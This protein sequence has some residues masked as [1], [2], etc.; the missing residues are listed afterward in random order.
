MYT[1]VALVGVFLWGRNL[2]EAFRD[3]K[4]LVQLDSGEG[5][6]DA[7]RLAVRGMVGLVTLELLIVVT[8][9][10]YMFHEINPDF[11]LSSRLLIG[12]SLTI[13]SLILCNLAIDVRR[14][15]V[16]QLDRAK[17]ELLI[18]VEKVEDLE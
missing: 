9:I 18:T 13:G 10:V 5:P 14:V 8:G 12:G 6:L 2:R 17:K 7:A 11:T 4:A 1:L 3:R 16:R 15:G